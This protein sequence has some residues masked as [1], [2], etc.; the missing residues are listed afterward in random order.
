MVA[1]DMK[2]FFRKKNFLQLVCLF[3]PNKSQPSHDPTWSSKQF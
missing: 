3:E 1:F 2:C